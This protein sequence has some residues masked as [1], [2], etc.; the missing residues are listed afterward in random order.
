MI[1]CGIVVN[2]SIFFVKRIK[3]FFMETRNNY[4]K[5]QP[6]ALKLI[7]FFSLFSCQQPPIIPN[8]QN[9]EWENSYIYP[10]I[11]S[12]NNKT[13]DFAANIQRESG[14]SIPHYIGPR[15]NNKFIAQLEYYVLPNSQLATKLVNS[16]LSIKM[17]RNGLQN[18]GTDNYTIFNGRSSAYFGGSSPT[19]NS[20]L[21]NY[22]C[23]FT[24]SAINLND[25]AVGLPPITQI[26]APIRGQKISTT[27]TLTIQFDRALPSQ[28]ENEVLIC[29]EFQKYTPFV[30]SITGNPSSIIISAI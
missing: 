26:I 17:A 21:D 15:E 5:Y 10:R 7:V 16:N 13:I 29:T 30:K 1:K 22:T 2:K 23:Y 8:N 9:I 27:S 25:I 19:Y 20:L 6:L 3:G 24:L 14:D 4:L 28:A 11:I 12:I 18:G